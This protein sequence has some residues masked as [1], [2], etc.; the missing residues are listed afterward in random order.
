VYL[1][2]VQTHSSVL[3]TVLARSDAAATIYFISQFFYGFYSRAATNQEQRL[4][5]SLL[6]VK[7]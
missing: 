6:L 7:S 1:C 5:N 2:K 4:L 3:I